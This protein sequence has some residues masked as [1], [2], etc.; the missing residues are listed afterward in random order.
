ML[1]P[2]I[3]K[4]DFFEKFIIRKLYAPKLRHKTNFFRLLALAQKSWLGLRDALISIK[5]S[6]S[7]KWLVMI[8]QDLINQLTQWFT[9]S[10]AMWNHEY[11]F[12][13]EEIELVKSAEVMWNLPEIL[14]EIANE[15]ENNQRITQKIKKAMTYPA[16]LI[17]FAIIAVVILLIYVIPTI[18]WM[19]PSQESL[20]WITKFML[21]VSS[22]IK[23][24]RPL[25]LIF[26]IW[27]YVLYKFLYKYVLVF[28]MVVDKL[29][30]TLP[31]V[32]WV[33]KTFYMY[34]F[35]KLLSQ[36]YSAWVSPVI[37]LKLISD[38]FTNFFYKKKAIEI[39]RDLKAWFT[40]AESMEWS[41]LF[42]PILVQIIH[43]WE[44]TWNITE[45][46]KKMSN[47]YSDLLQ[48]KIDILMALIEPL[49][50]AIIAV[51]IWIL[52]GSIFLPMADLVNV[53][54]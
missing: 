27:I 54:K 53:I 3:I 20:P 34:R 5:R 26:V 16:V 4:S 51:I 19:F 41:I 36:L 49:M 18:V 2:K 48:N 17:L 47:F 10:Q 29:L 12:K 46:L 23:N 22:I 42:D 9:L 1:T 31:A 39:W 8:I 25:I 30:I 40:F 50:M 13:I 11:F 37:S 33:T 43:V 7:H 15:L 44:D 38:V 6:E 32:G 35:S 24:T 21:S 28:K 52:V 14:E 45:I